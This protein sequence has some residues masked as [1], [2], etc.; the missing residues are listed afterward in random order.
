MSNETISQ[1]LARLKG[2]YSEL[3]KLSDKVVRRML[4][5]EGGIAALES[6]IIDEDAEKASDS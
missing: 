6:M 1:Q 4:Q 5:V 2:E 3:V